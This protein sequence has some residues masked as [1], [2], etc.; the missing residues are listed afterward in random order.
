M[1]RRILVSVS[2]ALILGAVTCFIVVAAGVVQLLIDPPD[3]EASLER[4][5][6]LQP[7]G[8]GCIA[9]FLTAF[10]LLWFVRDDPPK[11][12]NASNEP[13]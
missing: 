10:G 4:I 12:P 8:Y 6:Q 13:K 5:G 1:I 3:A 2:L 7:W 9:L 11:S